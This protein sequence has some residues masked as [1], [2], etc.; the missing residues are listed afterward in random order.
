MRYICEQFSISRR[1]G[2]HCNWWIAN[3]ML[4]YVSWFMHKIF[5]LEALIT[6]LSRFVV[7]VKR[8][9]YHTQFNISY[10]E[11]LP[12]YSLWGEVQTPFQSATTKPSAPTHD[13]STVIL[14]VFRPGLTHS[15]LPVT[16]CLLKILVLLKKIT[17]CPCWWSFS[18]ASVLRQQFALPGS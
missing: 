9:L 7:I 13:K 3:G 14:I 15:G 18:H 6:A 4:F 8:Y 12:H 17:P 11:S 2:R 5:H 10:N 16:G 1:C